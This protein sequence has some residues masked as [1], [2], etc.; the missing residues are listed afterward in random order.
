MKGRTCL[1]IILFLMV[2]TLSGAI[3]LEKGRIRLFVHEKTGRFS[4]YHLTEAGKNDSRP[5]FYDTDPR[6]SFLTI[7]HDN[8]TFRMGESGEFSMKTE[9]TRDTAAII[10]TS[11][12]L[13]ISQTFS[14]F[15]SDGIQ[16]RLSIKNT[17]TRESRLGARYLIDT[18]LGESSRSHFATNTD[19]RYPGETSIVPALGVNYFV[20]AQDDRKDDFGLKVML[21]GSG[22]SEAREVVFANWKRL[23]E[24]AWHFTVNPSRNYSLMPYSIN[25]SAAALYYSEEPLKPGDTREIVTLMG[26]MNLGGR[27]KA[28]ETVFSDLLGTGPQ[29]GDSMDSELERVKDFLSRLNERVQ[30]G[31]PL[32]REEVIEMEQVMDELKRRKSRYE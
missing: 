29:P 2:S 17:G 15:G 23:S 14:F 6:T 4:L 5:L 22:I 12:D 10:W 21:R 18:H 9:R 1:G 24:T 16:I 13:E 3:E 28:R 11:S 19:S 7:V 20:S 8:K 30:S 31:N 27:E 26:N 32:T 25:D